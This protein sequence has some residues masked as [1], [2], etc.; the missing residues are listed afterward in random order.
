MHFTPQLYDDALFWALG[1]DTAE[2]VVKRIAGY[3]AT[4]ETP[5]GWYAL[6]FDPN[7]KVANMDVYVFPAFRN[8]GA[9]IRLGKDGVRRA[10]EMGA[11]K[12]C[13]CVLSGNPYYKD[14]KRTICRSLGAVQE[15]TLK[16]HRLF[17]GEIR[18]I[19]LFA[20][21]RPDCDNLK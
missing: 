16:R 12:V 7:S 4:G 17:R 5:Q 2:E 9:G 10:W 21:F 14:A 1:V 20:T 6:R 8:S 15:G 11:K 18:D 3:H 13:M 19:H